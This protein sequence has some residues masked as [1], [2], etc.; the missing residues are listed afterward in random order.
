[1]TKQIFTLSL[2]LLFGIG[3]YAQP[4]AVGEPRVIA[5]TDVPLTRPV[6]SPDGEKLFLN[7]GQWEVTV[8][9]AGLRKVSDTAVQLRATSCTNPLVLQIISE[10][11]QVA[12]QVEGLKSLSGEIVF[13]PVLSPQ[14]DKI[15]FQAGNSMYICNAD[16]SELRKLGTALLRATWT[17][18][19]K[20]I[21]VGIEGNDGH[22]ITKGELV[23][24]DIATGAKSM[25]FSSDKY[26]AFSPAISPDGKKLAFEDYAS[27]AIYIMDIQQ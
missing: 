2:L 16:G 24:V 1:M 7:N 13:N 10:P 14:G 21:V 27:G 11:L 23:S 8:S 4:K 18:D 17:A 26:I 20:Y 6:W 3:L 25:L 9:G 19:G 5:K 22:F 15:A 12:S